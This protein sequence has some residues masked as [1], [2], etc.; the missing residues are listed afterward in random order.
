MVIQGGDGW[1]YDIGFGGIDHIM[2]SGLDFTIMVLD[3][4]VYSNT[5]GQKSK[6]TP[7]GAVAKFAA[8][9][10]RTDKKDLGAVTMAYPNTYVASINLGA[11]FKHAVKTM[12][13]AVEFNGPSL[14][15]CYT[16]CMEHGLKDMSQSIASEKMAAATGYWL[17]FNRYPGKKLQLVTPKPA[18][19]VSE[20][21]S[22]QNRF[23]MLADSRPEEAAMLAK[24]L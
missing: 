4:E 22:Q 7:L 3:T 12:R 2:A 17:S 8:A 1:A 19:Q 13:E 20:F 16:P 14:I 21:L 24:D 23:M 5:G 9:G 6:A 11:N 10:K 18:K 15:V